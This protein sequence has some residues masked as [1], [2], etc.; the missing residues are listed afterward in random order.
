ME[1]TSDLLSRFSASHSGLRRDLSAWPSKIKDTV[2]NNP[3][4]SEYCGL[5]W[6]DIGPM[7]PPSTTCPV[8]TN[9]EQQSCL[10]CGRKWGQPRGVLW[11][12]HLQKCARKRVENSCIRPVEVC[13]KGSNKEDA[14][15]KVLALGNSGEFEVVADSCK[16]YEILNCQG[17]NIE[18][19]ESFNMHALGSSYSCMGQQV[20]V[21]QDSNKEHVNSLVFGVSGIIND[22]IY[23]RLR[24]VNTDD[25]GSIGVAAKNHLH[26]SEIMGLNVRINENE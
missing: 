19:V 2:R 9:P 6:D 26:G 25:H 3:T 7:V 22:S 21:S 14:S 8:C 4:L 17:P 15:S 20:L 13:S 12:S 11:Y 23:S 1:A 16:E 24:Y 18:M 5:K 10:E